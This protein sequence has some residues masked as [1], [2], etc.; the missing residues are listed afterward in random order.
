MIPVRVAVAL[1]LLVTLLTGC[2][3]HDPAPRHGEPRLV[4][5]SPA[6]TQAV[7]DLGMGDAIVGVAQNDDAAP[8]HA[9]VVG[10]YTDINLEA[11]AAVNPTHV[12]LQAGI[13]G[14][15]RVLTD[16]ADA[17]RL[18]LATFPYPGSI[19]EVADMLHMDGP[20]AGQPTL[21]EVLQLTTEA[22]ALRRDMLARIEAIRDVVAG[23][24]RPRVLMIFGLG[25]IMASGGGTVLNQM[26][27]AAGGVNA[28]P[29]TATAPTLDREKLLGIN[30]DVAILLLPG[31][32]PLESLDN[33]PRLAELRGPGLA[34]WEQR[35]IHLINDKQALLPSTS[36]PR[37]IAAMARVLH[38]DSAERIDAAVALEVSP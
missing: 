25:P 12:M 31:S 10:N 28:A 29:Q 35:R 33:D 15:P 22:A 5:L 36:M 14:P 6:L 38:P 20:H 30:A 18:R 23:R 9:A 2:G 13:S 3:R 19:A 32:P 24:P 21:G 11:L 17:G 26:L 34:L 27:D 37:I 8:D 1:I 4:C 7:I 16:L